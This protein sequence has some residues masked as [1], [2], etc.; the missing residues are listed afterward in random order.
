MIYRMLKTVTYLAT[1]STTVT[2]DVPDDTDPANVE[3]VARELAD[4]KFASAD[5]PRTRICNGC[6]QHIDIGDFEQDSS[7]GGVE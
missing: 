5:G 7:D 2:V 4:E 1:A 6:A 3:R